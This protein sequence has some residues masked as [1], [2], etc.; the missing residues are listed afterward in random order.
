MI[1][2]GTPQRK[3]P[4]GWAQ[5]QRNQYLSKACIWVIWGEIVLFDILQVNKSFVPLICESHLF[6]GCSFRG[7]LSNSAP[8]CR[9]LYV[10]SSAS[11][12]VYCT[13]C[14][15]CVPVSTSLS[16]ENVFQKYFSNRMR[17]SPPPRGACYLL[18]VRLPLINDCSASLTDMAATKSSERRTKK[19]KGKEEQNVTYCTT[20]L[21]LE[22]IA[23][24][25]RCGT[26]TG[27]FN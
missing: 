1:L 14:S 5:S 26:K 24:E 13:L 12:Y 19:K 2:T 23:L 15:T 9:H 3:T 22:L 18:C 25:I 20:E 8:K 17:E 10:C 27:A 21:E 11:G 16:A 6:P 7:F 4:A